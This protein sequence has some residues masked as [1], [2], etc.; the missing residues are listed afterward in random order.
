MVFDDPKR[1]AKVHAKVF[2]WVDAG[3]ITADQAR[4][5]LARET[6]PYGVSA[7]STDQAR[8][9]NTVEVLGYIGTVLVLIAAVILV[10]NAWSE[11]SRA[12]RI[13]VSGAGGV[14]LA[15]VGLIAIRSA[16]PVLIRIGRVSLM[17]APVPISVAVAGTVGGLANPDLASFFSF[18]AALGLSF[19]WYLATPSAPQ[20]V[21]L[22]MSA[23]GTVVS[24]TIMLL[25]DGNWGW[26]TGT[27]VVAL[28]GLWMALATSNRLAEQRLGEIL[29]IVLWLI[30]E[31]VVS[32]SVVSHDGVV[33]T[34]ASTAFVA[35]GVAMTVFGVTRGRTPLLVGGMVGLWLF[36]PLLVFGLFNDGVGVPLA[37]LVGGGVLVGSAVLL[38]KR[39]TRSEST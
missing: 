25:P 8:Q 7:P 3:I 23:F 21:A 6:L 12:V 27:G 15:G 1:H 17:L 37:F 34:L 13:A 38:G 26:V 5:I 31:L 11:L 9:T 22:I 2:Q 39:S 30:G 19:W 33:P 28:G 35:V 36:L 32:L 16:A 4:D 29:G 10:S 20:H 14:I 18:A 24:A